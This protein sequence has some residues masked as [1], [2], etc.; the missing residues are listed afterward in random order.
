MLPSSSGR[1]KLNRVVLKDVMGIKLVPP[2]RPPKPDTKGPTKSTKQEKNLV[3]EFISKEDAVL[4]SGDSSE[5][6]KTLF[7]QQREAENGTDTVGD[8]LLVGGRLEQ[9]ANGTELHFSSGCDMKPK[10]SGPSTRGKYV[11]SK[12]QTRSSS[13]SEQQRRLCRVG[14]RCSW[15]RFCADH[16]EVRRR[17]R[18]RVRIST[19][20]R[21][22]R[23]VTRKTPET[24]LTSGRF[25][26][27][28]TGFVGGRDGPNSAGESKGGG[29]QPA[30]PTPSELGPTSSKVPEGFQRV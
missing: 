5:P 1:V 23:T 17:V 18:R 25:R 2:R 21:M 20:C 29:P 10:Q 15:C 8:V 11:Q 24:G 4:G 3:S 28:K 13:L 26:T 16:S 27:G 14:L 7:I 9:N 6:F 19:S 30:A 12:P 22:I